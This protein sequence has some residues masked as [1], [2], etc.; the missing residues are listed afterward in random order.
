[1]WAVCAA[2]AAGPADAGACR[3]ICLVDRQLAGCCYACS[4]QADLSFCLGMLHVL[5][6]ALQLV[7][8]RSGAGGHWILCVCCSG[9]HCCWQSVSLAAAL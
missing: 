3:I 7:S 8:I 1:M 6:L 5:Q 4:L 2:S 9:L